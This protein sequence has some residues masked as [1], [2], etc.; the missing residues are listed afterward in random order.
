[1]PEMPMVRASESRQGIESYGVKE[2]YLDGLECQRSGSQGVTIRLG[3]N[4]QGVAVSYD[5]G[6][7]DKMGYLWSGCQ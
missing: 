1:M 2:E 5:Y 4:G 7:N 3:A 6:V